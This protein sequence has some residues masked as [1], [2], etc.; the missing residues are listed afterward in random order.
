MSTSSPWLNDLRKSIKLGLQALYKE[1]PLTATEWADKHFYMSAESSYNEGKWTTDPFQVA[2]LNSMGNDL[3]KF[4]NF[5]K[6]ARIGY[7][8]LLM[9]N[10]GYKIQHKRRNVMM[11]SPTDPD[12]EDISKSHVS[13]MIRDVPVIGELAPWFGKKHSNNTLDQK[14]FS[15]RRTLWIKGGTASRNFREKSADEV[16]YDELSN[17]DASIEGEGSPTTLGDKRLKGATYPKS[18][19]GST[20]KRVGSC[21]ITK[22]VEES[23]YLLRFHINCPHCQKEQTLQW[24]GKDCEFGLKWE[25]NDLGEATKAW[26]LC[27]HAACVIWHNEMVEASKTGRWICDNTGISTRDGMDWLDKSGEPIRTPRSVSFSV[28]AIY[29]TWTTWLELVDEWLNVKGDVEK[30]ITFINTTRGETWDDDQGEKLDSEVL[31]G[32][33]EVYPQVP[34]LGLVLVGGIDTQDDRFEGRVWAF[35]PGEEAWLVHRFILMGDPASEELRRKVGLELH[36]QFTRVDG[37]VMKV[38]RWTWDAGGHYAD[39]V[40]AESRKHGV[41]WVV[42]IRGATI[43]GKPIANFP[44]TKNKVHKVFLTEV[45]TDN[46]KELLYSRMGLPVN[47]AASQ[48][49]LSQPGVV[50][51]PADDDICDESEVKQ[52]TSEKKKAAISKGKRVMRWDSGGRRNEALDC[53]VYALAALRICQQRFGLDLDLLVA[54]V[55]GGNEPDAEERPRKKS[56]HWNKN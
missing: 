17:F 36:R 13:G 9:A 6:S 27:E 3:I 4:V 52:L 51:L 39:E 48:S 21:Q 26:Y 33:R 46:A 11:W 14:I 45:G 1:P 55:T 49:A 25:K 28:W 22:A 16:I 7:T 5:I 29:S 19:R 50:H 23:P 2:I 37:T 30:L 44:R 56:S 34:A 31:Y 20:P 42:P 47:T 32:R 12:A 40:Y 18:I 54:A 38:E 35:G 43:Y 53:F 15:N 10:I 8:K 41:H 24:G